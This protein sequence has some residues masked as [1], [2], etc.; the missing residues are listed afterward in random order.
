MCGSCS[1]DGMTRHRG[2][3]RCEA[4]RTS[5]SD[6]LREPVCEAS[7]RALQP[8]LFRG[9]SISTGATHDTR[10]D[11]LCMDVEQV[12]KERGHNDFPITTGGWQGFVLPLG[13]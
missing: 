9:G 7:F 13:E 4:H 2:R 1:R 6:L 5:R 11:H 12:C 8:S 10:A 3:S